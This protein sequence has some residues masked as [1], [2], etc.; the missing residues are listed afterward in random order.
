MQGFY[1]AGGE[2]KGHQGEMR[3]ALAAGSS[4]VGLLAG[5]TEGVL[6]DVPR[7]V[8]PRDTH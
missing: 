7:R 4:C 8:R 6:P 1:P 2:I 5:R 3:Y